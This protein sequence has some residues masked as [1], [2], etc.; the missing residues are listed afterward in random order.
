MSRTV[1]VAAVVAA[2]VVAG[3]A[4]PEAPGGRPVAATLVPPA[5]V[6]ALPEPA[7]R[8]PVGSRLV[9]LDL[10][11]P[12]QAPVPLSEGM[13]AAGGAAVSI[14]GQ[15]IA[16]VGRSSE[17][18]AFAVW[19]TDSRA[20]ERRLLEGAPLE[21]GGVAWLPEGRLVVAAPV[22]G[23]PPVAGMSSA[24]A[25]FVV[26]PGE[27]SA[28]RI[29]FGASELDPAVLA[30]GRIVYSQWQPGGDGRPEGGAFALFTVHSDGT[31]AAP[32]HGH[33]D[34]APSKLWARQTVDGDL[35]YVADDETAAPTV[36]RV[37]WHDPESP[38][39]DLE[40]PGAA[41]M[42]AEVTG[43][44]EIFVAGREEDGDSVLWRV[45]VS[46]TV[47]PVLDAPPGLAFA[48]GVAI[49]ARARPQGH[50]SMVDA[51]LDEGHLLCV[52][53]RP[54]ELPEARTVRLWRGNES[55]E[56]TV[57]GDVDLAE[58]GSF[59]ALVPADQPLYLELLDADRRVLTGTATPIW[60]RPK[61]VRACVGCHESQLT[62]P[63]NRRPLAVLAE[64]VD[65]TPGRES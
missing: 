24:W 28:Q 65:L 11:R 62:A 44:G 7:L 56:R 37:D 32:L 42:S 15:T 27:A 13:A 12:D 16:F 57:L 30:D 47:T 38:S 50:L 14:D 2:L 18:E 46:G 33:H 1:W 51:E 64:P 4:T 5:A 29:T 52:D 39:T 40:L 21:A 55:G 59:F 54:A 9:R 25:L 3:C 53:A 60:V 49:A 36:Q 20:R 43:S 35:L 41:V 61:E 23:A 48:Q 34:G 22:S 8:Y 19:L 31:G 26:T 45:D 10:E 6:E 17:A 58:D 63:P